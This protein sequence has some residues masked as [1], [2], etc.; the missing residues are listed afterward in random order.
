MSSIRGGAWALVCLILYKWPLV[1]KL[2]SFI[3]TNSVFACAQSVLFL[4]IDTYMK[5]HFCSL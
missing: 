5:A 4:L 3:L 2:T 1:E